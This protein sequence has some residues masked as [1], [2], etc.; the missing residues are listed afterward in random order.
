VSDG[1]GCVGGGG[2]MKA[3]VEGEVS[4]YKNTPV[5]SGAAVEKFF[6]SQEFFLLITIAD[7][8]LLGQSTSRLNFC[9]DSGVGHSPLAD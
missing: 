2:E 5:S 1:E 9:D 4:K 7:S 8:P 3:G 6:Q